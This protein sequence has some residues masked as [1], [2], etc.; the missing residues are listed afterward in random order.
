MPP[1]RLSFGPELLERLEDQARFKRCAVVQVDRAGQ[2]EL[3]CVGLALRHQRPAGI[4]NSGQFGI[5]QPTDSRS[6]TSI[7][8]ARSE[9][10]ELED[11][12]GRPDGPGQAENV[13]GYSR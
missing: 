3:S 8:A 11:S 6:P 12:G 4:W 13:H 9:S 5:A 10:A 7:P 1:N 2:D